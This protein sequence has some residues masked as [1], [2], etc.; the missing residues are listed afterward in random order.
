M[1]KNPFDII[2]LNETFCDG[3]IA[4]NEISLPSYSIVRKDRNRHGGGVAIYIRNSLTFIRREDLETDDVECIW[5]EIKC[6]QRQ[7]VLI[8]SMYRPPSS[9]IEF[10]DKVGD[11]I[12][13]ASC[14]RKEMIVTGDFNYDVSISDGVVN[15]NP[16]TSCFDLFQMTQLIN[17]PTRITEST[18]TTID[19]IFSSH[20]ELINECGVLPVLLSDHYLVYGTHSWTTPKMKG[21]S[22][23]FRCYKDIDSDALKE[24]FLN[25]PWQCVLNC[26]DVDEAWCMWHSVF[27]RIINFHAPIKTKR[28]RGTPLP[29]LD[30]DILQ[31]MRQR[32]HAHKTAKRS[33]SQIH[34]DVYKKLRNKVTYKIRAKKSEYFASTIEENKSNSSMLWKKLKEILPQKQKY[35]PSSILSADGENIHDPTEIADIFNEHFSTIGERLADHSIPSEPEEDNSR[36]PIYDNSIDDQCVIPDITEEFVRKQISSMSVG[37]TTGPDGISVKMIKIASPY[38]TKCLTHIF[39]LSI[40]CGRYPKDWKHA[41]VTPIHKGGDKCSSSNYRPISILPIVS[42][43]LERWVHSAVY[44][45]LEEN[46][47]IPSCQSGFRPLHSTETTLHD[48]TNKCFQAM[49]NGEVTGSVFIDLSK[50]FDCVDHEILVDKLKRLNM[51]P[52]VISWFESYLSGRSQSVKLDDKISKDLPLNVGVPQGS[53]LGPLLFIIYTSDLP[54]CIPPN[55]NLFMYADDS[56]LTCSSSSI[57]EVERSLNVALDR[58]HNWCVRNKL[59]LNSNK[60]KCMIIG[61]RQKI[62]D[63]ELNVYIADKLIIK[64]KCCKCLGVIIDDTL[65]WGPHVEYVRKAVSSKLGM[66]NRIRDCVTQNSLLTLFI[67]LVMPTL[68]YCCTVW[69]GR[70]VSHDNTLNKCLKRAARMILKCTSLAPSADMFARLNWISFPERVKF[71]KATLV[72][73]CLNKMTPSY[74]ANLFTPNAH[75]RETRQSTNKALKVPLAKKECYVKSFAVSGANIWNNLPEQLRRVDSLDTFKSELRQAISL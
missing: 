63:A 26:H 57:N 32:D 58:I 33:G 41:L 71:K 22:I 53:I 70:Y 2:C 39:N 27:M 55:C 17:E 29:W 54:S 20:P 6:K 50:A 48:F 15:S 42:K 64:E 59:R 65:S 75:I 5:V 45:Y 46:T 3:S 16:I 44:T 60:T 34:W 36:V 31:L 68:E 23:N 66:L 61:T 24:D 38:V 21:R 8:S 14:E 62:S 18:R 13:K 47:L 28:I 10:V 74:V 19:L 4:D 72:F 73:K 52:S 49:E 1:S 9:C 25:A 51:S 40:R 37:K 11:I 67:S 35:I 7:P 69:G 30:G 56:T 43:I 12:D